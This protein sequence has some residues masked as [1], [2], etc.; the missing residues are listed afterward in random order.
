MNS[1]HLDTRIT[2]TQHA[3]AD[4][5]EFSGDP[6][7]GVLGRVTRV[8]RRR[9]VAAAVSVAVAVLGVG[10]VGIAVAASTGGPSGNLAPASQAPTS[11]VSPGATPPS[12]SSTSTTRDDVLRAEVA[13]MP[14]V[15]REL[16]GLDRPLGTVMC[17]IRVLGADADETRLFVW[18]MCGDFT[19][20]PNATMGSAGSEPAV[21]TVR[22]T[23]SSISIVDA[24]FPR[25]ARL[26]E[27]IDRMFPADIAPIVRQGDVVVSP[28]QTQLL[29]QARGMPE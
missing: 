20:G 19:T 8:R 26:E 16:T 1:D 25:Q 23:G 22:G 7:P 12:P 27:D 6:L 2:A 24:E 18:L 9:R 13:G 4:V 14:D 15:V 5:L 17:G 21:L 29:G 11:Q 28:T 10:G 3:H